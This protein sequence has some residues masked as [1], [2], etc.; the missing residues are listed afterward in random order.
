MTRWC[1]RRAR[2]SAVATICLCAAAALVPAAASAGPPKKAAAPAGPAAPKPLSETLAGLAL[3]EYEGG[4]ILY[5][6]GDFASAVLKFQKA[7]ELSADPRLLIN[8]A[9]CEKHLRRYTR[10]L[11][12]LEKVQ[13]DKSPLVGERDRQEIAELIKAVQ[14]F[15]SP[16]DLTVSEPGAS[17]LVDDERVGTAPLGG[18]ILLDVGVRRIRVSKAGFKDAL[19][20][21]EVTGGQPI[22]LTIRLEK[23]VHRGRLVVVAGPNDLIALDGKAVGRARWEGR[24]ESGGHTLRVTAPGM[25]PYQS[26]VAVKDDERR[27]V[28]VTLLAQPASV[29]KWL[30][31]GGGVLLVAGAAVGGA[32]LFKPSDPKAPSGSLGTFQTSFKIPLGGPR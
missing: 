26:E 17:V 12:T 4:K 20:S 11:A 7:W 5:R 14:A 6:S 3:A 2:A 31:V 30:W 15:V 25:H 28:E 9:A 24:V 29:A 27:Q 21:E 16:L 8:V 10:M 1:T 32:F 23:E 13:G 18:P 19:R 22:A